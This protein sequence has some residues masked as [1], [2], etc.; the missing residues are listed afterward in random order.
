MEHYKYC[1]S[2]NT[3]LPKKYAEFI[4]EDP[5]WTGIISCAQCRVSYYY[6]TLQ[7]ANVQPE[8]VVLGEDMKRYLLETAKRVGQTR[9]IPNY[10]LLTNIQL[11]IHLIIRSIVEGGPE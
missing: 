9:T 8:R 4:A 2:C 11:G 7:F 3:A 1:V 5:A 6:P 10:E